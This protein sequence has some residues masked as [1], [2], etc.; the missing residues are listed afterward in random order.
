[1]PREK[2]ASKSAKILYRPI[3]I[4]S[5]I[6]GA[7]V[8]SQVFRQVYKRATPG[9]RADAPKPLESEYSLR[10]IL[11]GAALQ[12]AV[13]ATVKAV[14]DRGGARM[15]QRWTGEWPGD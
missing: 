4:T 8:A 1:M 14:I 10:E 5:S 12:G 7:L 9:D 3:G 13:F 2:P 15:F 11:I 6:V